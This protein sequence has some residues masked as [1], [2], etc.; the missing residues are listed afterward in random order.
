MP[1]FTQRNQSS[2]SCYQSI[3]AVKKGLL[4]RYQGKVS[5]QSTKAGEKDA[6]CVMQEI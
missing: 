1:K 3:Q 6:K 2:T 4:P 5:T